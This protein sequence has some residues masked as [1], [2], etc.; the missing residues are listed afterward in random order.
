MLGTIGDHQD[1]RDDRGEVVDTV[2]NWWREL[3][4]L[5]AVPLDEDFFELG[6][7]SLTLV[8]FLA[9]VEQRYAVE[10]PLVELFADDL[11][12]SVVEAMIRRGAG[13]PGG[14]VDEG[15]GVGP[16]EA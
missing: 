11:T 16:A 2:V 4:V 6:G 15:A 12:V 13:A 14:R 7:E 9:C 3:L 8:Q 5:E 10:L 1:A